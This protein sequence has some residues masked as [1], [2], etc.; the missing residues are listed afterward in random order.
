MTT[1]DDWL[2]TQLQDADFAA[3]YLTAAAE[4]PEPAVYLT[5]LHMVAQSRGLGAV[6]TAA[7]LTPSTIE[8]A[9]SPNGNPPWA[10]VTNILRATGLKLT[11]NASH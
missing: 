11:V 1:H 6:A 2:F 9:L 7:G 3:D 10:T 4:D 8:Q 5:A